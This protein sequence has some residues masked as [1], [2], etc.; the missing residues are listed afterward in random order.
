M[1]FSTKCGLVI[2]CHLSVRL[3]VCDVGGHDHIGWD[4]SEIISRLVSLGCSLSADPNIRVSKVEMCMGMGFKT[5]IPWIPWD[6]HGNGNTI[7]H[8]NG[9]GDGDGN[10]TNRNGN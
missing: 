10:M 6:S 2:A 7:S 1:H 3:S 5:G 9:D 4:S 8:G